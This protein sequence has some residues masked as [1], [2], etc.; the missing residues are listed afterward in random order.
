MVYVGLPREE[1]QPG[2]WSRWRWLYL[3][4]TQSRRQVQSISCY[5][6]PG[7]CIPR[8]CSEDLKEQVWAWQKTIWL[9]NPL[10]FICNPAFK[11]CIQNLRP[12]RTCAICSAFATAFRGVVSRIT[13]TTSPEITVKHYKYSGCWFFPVHVQGNGLYQLVYGLWGN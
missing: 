12:S 9:L 13:V 10:Y 5:T 11:A 3:G 2:L 6:W 1:W 4:R 8:Y 7:A